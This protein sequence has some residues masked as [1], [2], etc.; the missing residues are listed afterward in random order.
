[1]KS[2]VVLTQQQYKDMQTQTVD[3]FFSAVK[4]IGKW[5]LIGLGIIG[6]IAIIDEVINR[7]K[8]DDELSKE[9]KKMIIKELEHQDE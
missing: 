5:G 4:N 8:K 2:V 1:M 3:N 6:G 9:D 7:F